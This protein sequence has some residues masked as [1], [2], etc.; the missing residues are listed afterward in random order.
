MDR[1]TDAPELLDGPLEDRAAL[2]GN[3]RDLRRIN[4]LLGGVRLS[5]HALDALA[6]GARSMTMLD[7]GTGGADIPLALIERWRRAGRRL[8]VVA[9]DSRPEIVDLARAVIDGRVPSGDLDLRVADGRSLPF[10]DDAFDAVHASMVIHHL[11]PAEAVGM[12]AEMARV[13]RLGVVVNDLARGRLQF[14][15]AW[16]LGHALTGNRLTRHDAPLSVRRAYTRDEV[17]ALGAKAGVRV[18]HAATDSLRHRWAIAAV[19]ERHGI[20]P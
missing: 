19:G 20:R 8:S 7:I 14:A 11:E 13:A 18:V 3:L 16:L 5:A 15:G 1:L 10:A 2:A 4:R 12:L 9:T 6:P 17:A